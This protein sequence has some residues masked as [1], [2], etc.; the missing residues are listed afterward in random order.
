MDTSKLEKDKKDFPNKTNM[1]ETWDGIHLNLKRDETT[2]NPKAVIILLH[3]LGNY[4]G[5]YDAFVPQFQE[6]DIAI[7][8]YDARGHG[9]SEGKRGYVKSLWEMVDD[10]SVIVDLAKKENPDIPIFLMGHSMGGL[11]AAMYG[12]KYPESV[13]GIVLAAAVTR[14]NFWGWGYLPRP[15]D[16]N[17]YIDLIEACYGTLNLPE[18]KTMKSFS[19]SN[20]D[21]LSLKEVAVATL[22]AFKEAVDYL[23]SHR[24]TFVNSVLLL[25][26]NCDSSVSPE[27]S[28]QFYQQTVAKDKSLFIYSG[29]SHFLMLDPNGKEIGPDVVNWISDREGD[30]KFTNFEM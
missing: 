26:G 23:K 18:Y 28:M 30:K 22:N 7:Y 19:A 5:L 9:R 2:G 21:K 13:K 3:G 14:M 20:D 16:P 24:D 8:R 12:T 29:L 10:L 6:N 17:S 27:D 25:H 15:E 1:V 4:I 11:V